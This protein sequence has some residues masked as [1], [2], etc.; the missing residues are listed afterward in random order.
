MY[1]L[2]LEDAAKIVG[3]SPNVLAP[4]KAFKVAAAH[5]EMKE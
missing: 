4:P 5:L 2:C 1:L 3:G